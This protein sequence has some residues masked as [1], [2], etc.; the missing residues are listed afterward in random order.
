MLQNMD[1][2]ELKYGSNDLSLAYP[3]KTYD[4]T[5]QKEDDW[6]IAQCQ[7]LNVVSQGKSFEEAEINVIQ[8]IEIVLEDQGNT[9]EF[10]IS[11]RRLM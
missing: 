4:V 3:R 6:V 2:R 11:V 5:L 10:S 1:S 9:E 7:E 8:A